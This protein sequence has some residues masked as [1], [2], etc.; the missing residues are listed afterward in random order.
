MA[1]MIYTIAV[2]VLA[3]LDGDSEARYEFFRDFV[4]LAKRAISG[5]SKS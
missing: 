1:E 4:E 3:R 2:D 5:Y